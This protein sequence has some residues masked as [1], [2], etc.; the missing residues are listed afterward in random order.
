MSLLA[1]RDLFVQHGD[2][3]LR[4]PALEL[5]AGTVTLVCGPNG[6]GK[7]TL[8]LACAGLLDLKGGSIDLCG[9]LFSSGP[10]P[11]PARRR[12]QVVLVPQ[13]PYLLRGTVRRNLSWGLR[14][15]RVTRAQR[16]H[17]IEAVLSTVGLDGYANTRV[18]QL[19]GGQ[20]T[21]V[22][23]A[24]ALVL[25]PNVLLLDEV[26]RD[27]DRSH[28]RAVATAIHELAGQGPAVLLATHDTAMVETF[29]QR[30]VVLRDGRMVELRSTA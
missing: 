5:E 4:I 17:A 16:L 13:D 28:R 12:R 26:T 1:C 11:A 21:L 29:P 22:A 18:H 27:L 7:S 6:S 15:R 9:E 2:F 3:E 23:V 10:A 24:R 20:R 8:L 19:S 30:R 25:R 14:L